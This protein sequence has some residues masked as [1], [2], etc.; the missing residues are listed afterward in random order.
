MRT[1]SI[2]CA[3]FAAAVL[4]PVLTAASPL[5]S[6]GRFSS[7]VHAVSVPVN[8]PPPGEGTTVGRDPRIGTKYSREALPDHQPQNWAGR[9]IGP[10]TIWPKPLDEMAGG[11]AYYSGTVDS[12]DRGSVLNKA[13][14]DSDDGT[15][16]GN[17]H[18]GNSGDVGG[19]NVVNEGGNS[20]MVTI[21]NMNSNNGGKGGSSE[22]GCASGGHGNGRGSGGNGYSGNS[23]NAQGGNVNNDGG[24]MNIDSNNAGDAGTTKSGCATGGNVSDSQ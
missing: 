10:R 19:G 22:T 21:L 12:V 9:K 2:S 16:G 17:A 15:L 1:P 6:P 3:I 24:M 20:G 4:S 8:Q 18:S 23:G 7:E 13:K 5:P 14:R 11:N